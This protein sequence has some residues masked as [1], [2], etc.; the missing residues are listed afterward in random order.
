MPIGVLKSESACVAELFDEVHDLHSVSR[1]E[2]DHENI[3]DEGGLHPVGEADLG[4]GEDE[5]SNGGGHH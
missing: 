4:A 2:R 3:R 1:E 5:S